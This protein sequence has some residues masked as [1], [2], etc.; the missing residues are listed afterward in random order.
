MKQF[1]IY[2]VNLD[3]TIGSEIKKSRPAVIISPNVLNK[4]LNTVIIAPFT[5]TQKEYPSRLFF[6]LNN[7]NGEIVLDQLR[8]VDKI[9]LVKKIGKT[10]SITSQNIKLILQTMFS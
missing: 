8:P 1:E 10:D 7:K 3:P 2:L 4:M 5:S 9:R 6:N